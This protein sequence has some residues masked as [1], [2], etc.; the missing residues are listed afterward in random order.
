LRRATSCETWT[1][2]GDGPHVDHPEAQIT[3]V[4]FSAPNA[5]IARRVWEHAGVGGRV[6]AVVGTLAGGPTC[7]QAA[8]VGQ[9]GAKLGAFRVAPGGG[10]GS[11]P[12]GSGCNAALFGKIG[13]GAGAEA[14]GVGGAGAPRTPAAGLVHR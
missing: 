6:T 7:A 9:R 10:A 12:R 8:G 2:E 11:S 3:S 13:A 14:A 1:G 5:D 4:E